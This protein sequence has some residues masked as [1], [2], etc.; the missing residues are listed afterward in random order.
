M[1]SQL[2]HRTQVLELWVYR[3]LVDW[4]VVNSLIGI[5]VVFYTSGLV[6][7]HHQS[8]WAFIVHA[9]ARGVQEAIGTLS[10]ITSIMAVERLWQ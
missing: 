5:G 6:V 2:E 10:H 8:S 9:S 7:H 3:D 4:S 1:S